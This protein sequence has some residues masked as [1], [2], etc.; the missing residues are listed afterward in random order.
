M[1][2]PLLL[3]SLALAASIARAEHT[4]DRNI[5]AATWSQYQD[6]YQQSPICTK[7]EIT[8]WT[9]ETYHKQVF[10]LCSSRVITRTSGYIQYRASHAGKLTFVYPKVKKPPFGLFT[11]DS[12]RNGNASMSFSNNGYQYSLNDP[13]LAESSISVSD[14]SSSKKDMEIECSSGNQTLQLNYT[15]RLLIDSGLWSGD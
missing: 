9:C 13:I 12:Y 5:D 1:T 3:L 10:S 2:R 6:Q 14:P 11:F 15:L 4:P 7:D 8:L